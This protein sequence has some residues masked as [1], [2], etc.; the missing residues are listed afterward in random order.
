MA[1]RC[2]AGQRLAQQIWG[3]VVDG[4][5]SVR[6]LFGI[7]RDGA[8]DDFIGHRGAQLGGAGRTAA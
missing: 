4:Q 2:A 6:C 8:H 1:S 3:T 7:R 5:G